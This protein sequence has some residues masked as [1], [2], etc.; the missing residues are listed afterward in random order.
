MRVLGSILL[1]VLC[2]AFTTAA[3]AA[4]RPSFQ[5]A[6]AAV[7]FITTQVR[8][9]AMDVLFAAALQPGPK[10]SFV[11]VARQLR[12]LDRRTPLPQLYGKVAFPAGDSYSLG[13][14][15]EPWGHLHI[16][17]AKQSGHWYLKTIWLCR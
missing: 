9:D 3:P 10:E 13:G 15:G 2:L 16:D 5:R 6:D 7:E 4:Q 17:F 8:A 1:L 14:H 12:E 11:R